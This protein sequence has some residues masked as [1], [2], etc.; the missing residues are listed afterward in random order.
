LADSS[1]VTGA[2]LLFLDSLLPR[3]KSIS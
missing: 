2:C 3:R 1:I